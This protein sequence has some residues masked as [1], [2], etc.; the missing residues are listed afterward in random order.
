M[1]FAR[2]RRRLPS[3]RE[4]SSPELLRVASTHSCRTWQNGRAVRA[5]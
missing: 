3:E 2:T 4:V 5:L 1:L